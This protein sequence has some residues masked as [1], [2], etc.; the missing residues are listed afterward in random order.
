MGERG[1]QFARYNSLCE[2][3]KIPYL[4]EEHNHKQVGHEGLKKN[5]IFPLI[6]NIFQCNIII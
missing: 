4:E 2:G 1:L 5:R 6:I 3:P